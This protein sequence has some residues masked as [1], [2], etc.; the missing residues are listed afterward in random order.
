F[1]RGRLQ[2]IDQSEFHR[3]LVVVRIVE[4]QRE[5]DLEGSTLWKL[6]QTPTQCFLRFLIF[7][8]APICASQAKKGSFTLHESGGSIQ[9]REPLFQGL[10][11]ER[12]RRSFQPQIVVNDRG[13]IGNFGVIR[14][15]SDQF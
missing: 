12:D 7:S 6:A 2:E 10:E 9:A 13:L 4:G 8:Q 3:L 11:I 14:I 5:K 1:V 15:G